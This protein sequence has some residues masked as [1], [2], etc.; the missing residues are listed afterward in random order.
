MSSRKDENHADDIS[1]A[2]SLRSAE[3]LPSYTDG[4]NPL[5]S[6]NTPSVP[7]KSQDAELKLPTL[8]LQEPF[9]L[10]GITVTRDLCIAHLKLL[11]ALADL[12]DVISSNDGLFDIYDSQA[13]QFKDDERQMNQALARIREKRWAVYVTRAV[14]RFTTWW[15]TC[16]PRAGGPFNA[17]TLASMTLQDPLDIL[18]RIDWTRDTLPPLGEFCVKTDYYAYKSSGA[19]SCKNQFHT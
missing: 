6:D 3:H 5:A 8:N 4:E 10:T 14:D 2:T 12:R 18:T 7:T 1:D 13:N 9:P 15:E 17:S 11:A 16:V 19:G